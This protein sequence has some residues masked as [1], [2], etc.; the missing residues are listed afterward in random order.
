MAPRTLIMKKLLILLPLAFGCLWLAA[1]SVTT[2]TVTL[3]ANADTQARRAHAIFNAARTN[4]LAV[5]GAGTNAISFASFLE[6]TSTN[7]AVNTQQILSD[8]RSTF[9]ARFETAPL[10]KQIAAMKALQ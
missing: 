2:I 5:F 10:A 9:A 3:D 4:G 7:G 1:Q 6:L 8:W